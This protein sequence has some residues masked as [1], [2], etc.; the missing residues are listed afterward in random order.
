MLATA[1]SQREAQ[2]T[3][4]NV[5]LT[6]TTRLSTGPF[7]SARCWAAWIYGPP[8]R[9]SSRIVHGLDRVDD[10]VGAAPRIA[11]EPRADVLL[12]GSLDGMNDAVLVGERPAEHDQPLVDEAV[13][14]RGVLVPQPDCSSSGFAGSQSGPARWPVTRNIGTTASGPSTVRRR[15]GAEPLPSF[16]EGETSRDALER[17]A[18]SLVVDRPAGRGRALDR[19]LEQRM[20][21]ARTPS[22]MCE[23][24]FDR[25]DHLRAVQRRHARR[26]AQRRLEAAHLR[27]L[28]VEEPGEGLAERVRVEAPV[29]DRRDERGRPRRAAGRATSRRGRRRPRATPGPE[30][31]VRVE[32][33][34][35]HGLRVV[36]GEPSRASTA[37]VAAPAKRPPAATA[38][39]VSAQRTPSAS[40]PAPAAA[41]RTTRV[42]SSGHRRGD[43]AGQSSPS[44]CGTRAAASSK[45]RFVR[46]TV[47]RLLAPR[48]YWSRGDA[49]E[50]AQRAPATGRRDRAG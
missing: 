34:L 20:Q 19:H 29:L 40:S 10:E 39:T 3:R 9:A 47:R 14:E 22:Q 43:A 4:R 15:A 23:E 7:V 11:G 21:P 48:T 35:E 41:A 17:G 49:G 26:V 13:H 25:A 37:A 18:R 32:R 8:L 31:H 6:E 24:R 5:A 30:R 50:R 33:V 42:S 46:P 12:R 16:D 36:V 44:S 27:E 1:G 2:A 28:V 45:L 38:A